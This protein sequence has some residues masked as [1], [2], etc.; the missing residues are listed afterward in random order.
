MEVKK[1]KKWLFIFV[2]LSIFFSVMGI[3]NTYL[4]LYLEKNIYFYPYLS[5]IANP[6]LITGYIIVYKKLKIHHQ[7]LLHR[8]EQG[9]TESE[10]I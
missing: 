7:E 4:D 5:F 3:V 6:I 8:Y 10:K 9:F 1:D 2:F